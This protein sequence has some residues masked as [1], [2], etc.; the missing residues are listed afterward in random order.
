MLADLLMIRFESRKIL[1]V[2]EMAERSMADIMQEAGEP[3]EFFD[4]EGRRKI[5]TKD[6]RQRGIE[7]FRKDPCHVHRP[8]GMLE[9]G[10]FCRGK[11]PTGTLKLKDT[12]KS[13][14]PGGVNDIPLGSLSFHAVGHHDVMVNRVGNQPGELTF[15]CSHHPLRPILGFIG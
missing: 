8:E 12:P 10:M 13:L 11:N 4:I 3:E 14:N 2:E 6:A 7:P 1:F 9:A 15:F 5:F